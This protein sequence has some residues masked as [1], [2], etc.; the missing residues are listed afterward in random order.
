MWPFGLK[1]GCIVE[2]EPTRQVVWQA[3]CKEDMPEASVVLIEMLK[4]S[5]EN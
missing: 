2:G 3:P 1:N 4:K 5:N